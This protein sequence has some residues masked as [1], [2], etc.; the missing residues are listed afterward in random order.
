MSLFKR[1]PKVVDNSTGKTVS[2]RHA[3]DPDRCGYTWSTCDI[4]S[5]DKEANPKEKS[6]PHVCAEL[7]KHRPHICIAC[8]KEQV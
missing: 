5:N 6:L 2:G 8:D 3:K 4:R 7:G 1:D